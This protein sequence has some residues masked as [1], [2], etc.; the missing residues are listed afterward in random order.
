MYPGGAKGQRQDDI[1]GHA[2]AQKF[3]GTTKVNKP[4]SVEFGYFLSSRRMLAA[5][6][7]RKDWGDVFER[8]DQDIGIGLP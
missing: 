7:Q 3:L 8:V 5:I 4:N 6:E 1:R 2:F